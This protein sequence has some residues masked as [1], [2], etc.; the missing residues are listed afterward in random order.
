LDGLRGARFLDV[1]ESA[2]SPRESPSAVAELANLLEAKSPFRD[3]VVPVTIGGDPR[4]WLLTG[5]PVLDAEGEFAGY[6]GVGADVTAAK[7][8]EAQITHM[9]LHD[10]LTGLPNRAWFRERIRGVLAGLRPEESAALLFLDLD[11]F[12]GVN[13]TLGH[14]VGDALLR[15]V[16]QRLNAELPESAIRARLGGDEFAVF[17]A[18]RECARRAAALAV[19]IAQLLSAPFQIDAHRIVIGTSVGIAVAPGNGMTR[20]SS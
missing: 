4:W 17:F 2:P 3:I 5:K 8:S 6:R 7:R 18:G 13:D 1:L 15:A 20:T 10:A 11:R 12:K 9:A 16:T 14:P 19:H